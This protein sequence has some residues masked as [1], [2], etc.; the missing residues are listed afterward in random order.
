MV[1]ALS[2]SHMDQEIFKNSENSDQN[3]LGFRTKNQMA[4][5]FFGNSSGI[6]TRKIEK[7]SKEILSVPSILSFSFR[8]LKKSRRHQNS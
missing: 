3:S 1:Q 4:F 5:E 8:I 7:F 6:P 2:R